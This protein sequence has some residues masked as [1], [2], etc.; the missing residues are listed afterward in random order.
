MPEAQNV[1]SSYDELLDA[2]GGDDV[3]GEVPDGIRRLKALCVPSFIHD[4][5]WHLIIYTLCA[6][7]IG[8]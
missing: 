1:S 2:L 8:S 7:W 4:T 3:T 5:H 6:D